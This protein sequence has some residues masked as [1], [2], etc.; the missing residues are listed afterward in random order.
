MGP[1]I[2]SPSTQHSV[3][4]RQT[5]RLANKPISIWKHFSQIL[6]LP[7]ALQLLSPLLIQR[8]S[9]RQNRLPNPL[10]QLPNPQSLPPNPQQSQ[11]NPL[12]SLLSPQSLQQSQLN[13]LNPQQSLLSQLNPQ[14]S[15]LS[16][17]S[18]QQSQPNQ[19][20]QRRSPQSPHPNP[21]QSPRRTSRP[22]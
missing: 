2:P 20:N 7:Q 12:Q 4:R 21:L 22:L 17:Q 14:Q 19:Q 6:I 10:N 11:L 9:Q 8:Q 5:L 16:P 1:M 3:I 18:R 13:Q 15:L